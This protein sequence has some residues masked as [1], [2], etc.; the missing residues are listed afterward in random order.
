MERLADAIIHFKIDSHHQYP[1]ADYRTFLTIYHAKNGL[2]LLPELNPDNLGPPVLA[3]IDL[4]RWLVDCDACRAAVV[5]DTDDL[6]FICP[7]CGSS[8]KWQEITMPTPDDKAK[9]EEILLLR[10]G[11]R[12]ANKNRFWFPNE[13]IDDLLNQ[14][15]EHGAPVPEWARTP[16][17]QHYFDLV[18]SFIKE[19]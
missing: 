4:G 11:F 10:P 9:I 15:R 17:E 8:G 6:V 12:D 13:T 3:R 2:G 16:K 18:D 7:A 19:D 14:N 1:T 5:I